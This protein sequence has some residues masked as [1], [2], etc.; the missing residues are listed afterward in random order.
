MLTMSNEDPHTSTDM[1]STNNGE[2]SQV[3]SIP[4][5]STITLPL[6]P[7]EDTNNMEQQPDEKQEE[8]CTPVLDWPESVF[9]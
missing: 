2:A 4:T 8:K 9:L 5:L 6:L 1:P 7:N 3:S